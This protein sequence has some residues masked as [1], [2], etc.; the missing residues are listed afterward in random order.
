MNTILDGKPS[1]SG[2]IGVCGG[3]EKKRVTTQNQQSLKAK[4]R[5]FIIQKCKTTGDVE[6]TIEN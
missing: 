5:D 4:K 1:R 2:V 3:D 6:V